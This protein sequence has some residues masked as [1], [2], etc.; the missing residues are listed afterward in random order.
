MSLDAASVAVGFAIACLAWLVFTSPPERLAPPPRRFEPPP[1]PNCIH[2][3]PMLERV[4]D[5]IDLDRAWNTTE[6]LAQVR[7]CRF[8][9]DDLETEA[10]RVGA[11]AREKEKAEDPSDGT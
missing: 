5:S 10:Y 1:M 9:L 11:K 2:L 4:R 7:L 3:V 6:I 8:H